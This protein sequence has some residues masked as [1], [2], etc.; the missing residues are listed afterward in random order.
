LG[1][2]LEA[3]IKATIEEAKASFKKW[4]QEWTMCDEPATAAAHVA[5]QLQLNAPGPSAVVWTPSGIELL[6]SVEVVSQHSRKVSQVHQFI[7]LH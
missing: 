1:S 4:S 3:G 5:T 6:T 7:F 2:L